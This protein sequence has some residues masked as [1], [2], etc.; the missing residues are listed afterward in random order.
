[1]TRCRA[2]KSSLLCSVVVL[3]ADVVCGVGNGGVIAGP[4]DDMVSAGAGFV[5]T[6]ALA[7]GNCNSV[8]FFNVGFSG[9]SATG[10]SP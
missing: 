8:R 4:A 10:R 5:S 6:S 3:W 7:C 1:M 2:R 9:G